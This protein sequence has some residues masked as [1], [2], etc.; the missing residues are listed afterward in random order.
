MGGDPGQFGTPLEAFHKFHT[1]RAAHWPAALSSVSTHDTKRG[2]DARLR[3]AVLSEMSD[4]WFRNVQDWMALNQ[5]FKSAD[6]F[7]RPNEEQFFYQTVLCAW[8]PD[9]TTAS[10]TFVD[11]IEAYLLKV[12]IQFFISFPFRHSLPLYDQASKEAKAFTSWTEPNEAFETALKNFIRKALANER[13]LKSFVPFASTVHRC[14][15]LSCISHTILHMTLPGVPD[16]YQGTEMWDLS[17]VDPDNRRPPN[18]P[19]RQ[20]LVSH[21]L[22]A[23]LLEAVSNDKDGSSK[24]WTLRT[25][26]ALRQGLAVLFEKGSYTP[27]TLTGAASERVVA[28]QRVYGDKELLVIVGRFFGRQVTAQELQL[29]WDNT[30]VKVHPCCE[31]IDR[32]SGVSH[33]ATESGS[34][35]L[36]KLFAAGP[37]AVLERVCK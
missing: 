32:L 5:S 25:M 8:I 20:Q 30:T 3:L 29:E 16:V 24:M 26:L 11:R 12:W 14:M 34:L 27:A 33:I 15:R 6:G 35:S 13:F 23:P 22:K 19:Q 10:P 17:L 2:S 7:P 9:T 4:E 18:W 28:F 21:D 36:G 37:W 1:N 31:W